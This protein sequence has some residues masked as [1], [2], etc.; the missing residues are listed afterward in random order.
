MAIFLSS[1]L[2]LVDG[3][4]AIFGARIA[5]MD[6]VRSKR[7]AWMLPK[8]AALIPMKA[9][10][11]KGISGSGMLTG[12]KIQPYPLPNNFRQFVLFGQLGFQQP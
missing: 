8:A 3:N 11:P 9:K 12:G 7:A 6:E 2:E 4:T 1:V 10:T 5:G